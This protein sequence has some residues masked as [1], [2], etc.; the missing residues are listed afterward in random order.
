[1]PIQNQD[2]SVSRRS[3]PVNKLRLAELRVQFNF[4]SQTEMANAVGM[5]YQAYN[6][7]EKGLRPLLFDEAIKISR[8]LG[9]PLSELL[10]DPT[11]M[12][13]NENA[14]ASTLEKMAREVPDY[15]AGPLFV[16]LS[17]IR[18]AKELREE[19]QTL[20]AENRKLK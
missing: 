15:L 14:L 4:K 20:K 16:L 19:L 3:L 11:V 13:A 7:S 5:E 6:R 9:V 17:E 12:P 10:E 18:V 1:M 8:K 2:E